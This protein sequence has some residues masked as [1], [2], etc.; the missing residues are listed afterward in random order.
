LPFY[1]YHVE[2][3]SLADEIAGLS[4]QNDMDWNE[5]CANPHL[6]EGFTKALNKE[7]HSL[8]ETH[9]VLKQVF[10][11][12]E[13]YQ[14]AT[15]TVIKERWLADEK[16]DE[17]MKVRAVKQGFREI[18]NPGETYTGHVVSPISVRSALAN[19][20]QCNMSAIIDITTAFLQ[21]TKYPEGKVKYVKFKNPIT[22]EMMYFKQFGPLYGEKSAPMEWKTPLHH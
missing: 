18:L 1:A 22:G 12:D 19:H 14:T 6:K 17:S 16:R 7:F 2:A 20:K 4:R 5:I 3:K 15:D 21:S 8:C 11:G 9:G 10:P 13:D